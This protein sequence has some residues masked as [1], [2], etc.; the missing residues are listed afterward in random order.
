MEYLRQGLQAPM[1]FDRAENAITSTSALVSNWGIH[2]NFIM[3]VRHGF[4]KL[5]AFLGYLCVF[6]CA[7]DNCTTSITSTAFPTTGSGVQLQQFSYCGGV[8][9]VTAYIEVSLC[10][11]VACSTPFM[12]FQPLLC[13]RGDHSGSIFGPSV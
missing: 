8:L 6:S 7:Q 1:A 10:E 4:K 9:N 13:R 2:D 3:F 5:F 11:N 12:H